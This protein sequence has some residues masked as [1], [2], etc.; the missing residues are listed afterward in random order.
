MLI[1]AV[2]SMMLALTFYTI[3]VWSEKWQKTLKKWHLVMFW[4][5]FAFDTIGTTNMSIIAKGG[6]VFNFHGVTGLLAIILM[7]LHAIWATVVL[8]RGKEDMLKKFHK[9]SILVWFIWLI[10]FVSGAFYG[11]MQ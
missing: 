1:Y 10:P 4:V 2:I 8:A 3:G 6:F 11:M 9:F 7:F 5:G